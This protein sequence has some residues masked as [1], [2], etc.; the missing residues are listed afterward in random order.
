[1]LL[2]AAIASLRDNTA[3]NPRWLPDCLRVLRG[4][5]ADDGGD[6][7]VKRKASTGAALHIE[8][9]GK[10]RLCD[11]LTVALF[12]LCLA[13]HVDRSEHGAHWQGAFDSRL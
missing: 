8:L 13:S 1:M 7:G 10:A 11:I 9:I 12:F 2:Q 4:A 5:P 6:G 3:V